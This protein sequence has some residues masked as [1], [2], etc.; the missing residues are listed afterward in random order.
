MRIK[1]SWLDSSSPKQKA[2]C[3]YSYWRSV[4]ESLLSQNQSVVG[5]SISLCKGHNFSMIMSV[6]KIPVVAGNTLKTHAN[7]K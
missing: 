4:L 7:K 3:R 2:V 6:G 5:R 1:I